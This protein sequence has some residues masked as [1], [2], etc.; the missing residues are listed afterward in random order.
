MKVR[1]EKRQ[2]IELAYLDSQIVIDDAIRMNNYITEKYPYILK[3]WTLRSNLFYHS[4]QSS[5]RLDTVS[6]NLQTYLE[7][8]EN[9][10]LFIVVNNLIDVLS[11][12]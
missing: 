8:L 10:L 2:P 4:Q 3:S 11:Y 7:M 1:S 9:M 12:R 6:L 5:S